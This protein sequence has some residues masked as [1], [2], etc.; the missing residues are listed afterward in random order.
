MIMAAVFSP[1]CKLM[2]RDMTIYKRAA[3]CAAFFIA[4]AGRALR[5]G[6]FKN[7]LWHVPK[8]AMCGAVAVV[9]VGGAPANAAP[10]QT[11]QLRVQSASG[12]HAFSIEVADDPSERAQG[13]MWRESMPQDAGM[14]FVYPRPQPVSFWMKNT[15]IPLD[16]IFTDQ[17]GVI[18]SIHENAIPHDET[19]IFGGDAIFAV[20]ELNAGVSKGKGITIGDVI[21]HPAYNFFTSLPCNAN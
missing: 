7:S 9:I 13:L 14:L 5:F 12:D 8:A 1:Y 11:D 16:M 19:P 15:L 10:C 6:A 17:R 20:L 21:F 2:M 4:P 3:Q 18:V